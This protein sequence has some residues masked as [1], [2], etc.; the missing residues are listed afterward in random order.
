MPSESL[1]GTS[2]LIALFLPWQGKKSRTPSNR[3]SSQLLQ[4]LIE[5]STSQ[6][7]V[8]LILF[9]NNGHH[10]GSKM[11]YKNNYTMQIK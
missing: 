5:L 1:E 2:E 3:V 7:S 11:L 4:A 10:V 9:S 8:E 6:F